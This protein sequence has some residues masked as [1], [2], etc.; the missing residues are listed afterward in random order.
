M[1]TDVLLLCDIFEEF[2]DICFRYFR[3]D[4]KNYYT[5]S[6][7]AWDAL[8]LFSNA[9]LELFNEEDMY[10]FFEKGIWGGY[11]NIH[12]RYSKANHKYLANYAADKISKF[13]IDWDYNSMYTQQPC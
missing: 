13:L 9:R 12:K 2:S 1:Q 11:S 6:G 8:L 7:F 5:S 4:P 3:L 10:L